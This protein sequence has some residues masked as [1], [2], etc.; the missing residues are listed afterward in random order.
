MPILQIEVDEFPHPPSDLI[1]TDGV[2]LESDW[3]RLAMNLLIE[4]VTCHLRG[5]TDY[6]VGGNMFIYFN[7]QQA[8]NLDYRGPD[9]FFVWDRPLNPPR[10]YWAIWDEEGKYPDVIIELSSPRTI[11]EDRT[12]KKTIYERTFRTP[13]YYMYDPAERQLDGWRLVNHLYQPIQPNERGW[14][15]CEQLKLWLG[16]ADSTYSGKE[17]LYLRFFDEAGNLVPTAAEAAEKR[18][19]EAQL[20]VQAAQQRAEAER[21]RAETERTRAEAAEAELL[22]LKAQVASGG[23]SGNP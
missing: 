22:K 18:L 21:A 16:L 6:F 19:D 10:P 23:K 12:T 14:L 4:I 5:R 7:R 15:W 11:K 9:F 1:E 8:R 2:P 13:E 3:H 17:A 20:T